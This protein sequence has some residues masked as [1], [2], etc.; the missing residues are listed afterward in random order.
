MAHYIGYLLRF[1]LVSYEF[2][3]SMLVSNSN[4][5]LKISTFGS[6]DIV[7]HV[8]VR[9][10]MYGVLPIRGQL[11]VYLFLDGYGDM[12]LKYTPQIFWGSRR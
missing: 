6:R 12:D 9:L 2:L 1:T 4:T 5:S 3:K 10:A 7:G 8:A 11:Y